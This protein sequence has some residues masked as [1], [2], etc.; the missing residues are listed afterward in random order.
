[1]THTHFA[2]TPQEPIL[3][4]NVSPAGITPARARGL[5]QV[6]PTA[7]TV[8]PLSADDRAAAV[9]LTAKTLTD[10]GV[11]TTDRVVVALN[12]DG[13]LGG[14][15]VA[16]AAA[17][18][19]SA[20]ASVGPRG[21][22]RLLRVL[23]NVRANVLVG[24][25]TGVADFLARLHLEFLVDPLDL[26][27]RLILLTGEIAD[28]K[29]IEHLSREFGARTIELFTDPV[30]GVP[31]AHKPAKATALVPA[32]EDLLALA[33][34]TQSFPDG[35]L[36]EIVVKYPWHSGLTDVIAGTG[37]LSTRDGSSIAMPTHTY[38]DLTLIRGRWVS[39]SALTKA[40]KG[41]DGIAHWQL[42]ISRQGTLDSATV[43]V[44]FNRESLVQNG[45]W[46]ARIAQAINAITPISVQVEIDPQVREDSAPP[47]IRDERGHHL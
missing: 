14:A 2:A 20:A 10:A 22:M 12:S 36:A 30:S 42:R 45:M 39:F 37:Y 25:A 44:S 33:S 29:K 32:R 17:S 38:G 21:R 28:P 4:R 40:L 23:E 9:A 3:R 27:L 1:M 19:A 43:H 41:I 46:H 26:E 35:E 24:T 5:I 16:E 18:A 15:L 11:E 8:F 34:P 6:D 7:S 47:S 31:I 13:E